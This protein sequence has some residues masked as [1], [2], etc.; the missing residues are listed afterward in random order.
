MSIHITRHIKILYLFIWTQYGSQPHW[1]TSKIGHPQ[2]ISQD[3]I[4]VAITI[5]QFMPNN[6]HRSLINP[7]KTEDANI[8]LLE[9]QVFDS[10]KGIIL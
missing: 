7:L 10:N 6:T 4:T 8:N 3:T 2:D 1:I 9:F 5:D